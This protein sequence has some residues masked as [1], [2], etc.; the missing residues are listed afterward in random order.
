[1]SNS[2]NEKPTLSDWVAFLGNES[3][4]GISNMISLGA[5]VIAVFAAVYTL[6]SSGTHYRWPLVSF[7][8]TIIVAILLVWLFFSRLREFRNRASKA[9]KLL[10]GIMSGKGKTLAQLEYEWNTYLASK[11]P[12]RWHLRWPW[13]WDC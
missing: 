6:A 5:F 4:P 12:W 8:C 3:V 10:D 13:Y 1:M 2:S 11:K 9:R 7:F